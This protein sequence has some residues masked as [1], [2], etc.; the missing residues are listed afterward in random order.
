MTDIL[1]QIR[2]D[3]ACDPE[4]FL[5]WDTVWRQRTEL[6]NGYFDWVMAGPDDPQ[7]Q[8]GGL[9]SSAAL[10]TAT[11]ICLFTDARAPDDMELPFGQADRRGWWG[12][13]IRL[14][15]EPDRPLGSLIWTVRERG[16]VN[17]EAERLTKLY[18]DEA[19]DVLVEQGAVSRTENEPVRDELKGFLGLKTTHYD[20]HGERIY[21][22]KFSVLWTRQVAT[23]A[24][25]VFPTYS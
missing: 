19:L 11:I 20:E 9:R 12:D 6:G 16:I 25:M 5:Y 22:Q 8:R 18:A 15:G 7:D 3:E 24:Q 10:H 2:A 13:S 17:A 4:S 1:S 14:P 21:H 23:P